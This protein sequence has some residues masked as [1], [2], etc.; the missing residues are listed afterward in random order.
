M[1]SF[2]DLEI[3]SNVLQ[4]LQARK[5]N[6]KK[7]GQDGK[8]VRRLSSYATVERSG[9][10][11][12]F[13]GK[14]FDANYPDPSK[15]PTPQ[16][17]RVEIKRTGAIL[18]QHEA[19]TLTGTITYE[20]YTR[21][22]YERLAEVF[23]RGDQ[24]GPPTIIKW[25]NVESYDGRGKV[26][27]KLEARATIPGS[28][29]YTAKN[30]YLCTFSIVA[31][32]P[33]VLAF[34]LSTK[35]NKEGE[36]TLSNEQADR[37]LQIKDYFQ[38]LGV[39]ALSGTGE[40]PNKNPPRMGTILDMEEPLITFPTDFIRSKAENNLIDEFF[41]GNASLSVKNR[42]IYVGFNSILK[43]LNEGGI[44]NKE[45]DTPKGLKG[46]KIKFSDDTY[47]YIPKELTRD[48][49]FRSTQPG[50]VLWF[51]GLAGEKSAAN[52]IDSVSRGKPTQKGIDF[53]SLK[54]VEIPNF[55]CVNFKAY[56]N[57]QT[58]FDWKNLFF[59]LDFLNYL[60]LKCMN[61]EME[62]NKISDLGHETR[63]DVTIE[64]FIKTLFKELVT[65]SGGYIDLTLTMSNKVEDLDNMYIIDKYYRERRAREETD[66]WMFDPINNDGNLF[67]IQMNGSLP[68][69]KVYYLF[70]K[71]KNT[72][73]A[74]L[75]N[76]NETEIDDR[77][78]FELEEAYNQMAI[79]EFNETSRS[80]AISR[81][82][83]IFD[84]ETNIVNSDRNKSRV[85]S[86]FYIT[87]EVTMEGVYPWG[88]G[89]RINFTSAPAYLREGKN[90]LCFRVI[91]ITDVIEAP[92]VWTTTLGAVI[93]PD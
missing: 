9:T 36:V 92:N 11:L 53:G 75:I 28:F 51:N 26:E 40:S 21:D 90:G 59:N 17:K 5:N 54:D 35:T 22:D 39:L 72:K 10:T 80:N 43:W 31:P 62:P 25:G 60:Y 37:S 18:N 27:H 29:S 65:I 66:P 79:Q 68:K 16:L 24:D 52:Y 14:S 23:L 73:T 71:G 57:G 4:I 86:P 30:T 48:G 50:K 19:Y 7:T 61:P 13:P 88:P 1:K 84:I 64:L 69:D 38:K 55:A 76:N 93:T 89:N 78:I 46:M 41:L 34:Y 12:K 63:N 83:E 56:T 49:L 15:R 20:C 47:S 81:L 6:K 2:Y 44:K 3:D 91:N 58:K 67:D 77:K 70:S 87:A 74:A 32:G 8:F 33:T 85:E 82:K 45:D 42:Y